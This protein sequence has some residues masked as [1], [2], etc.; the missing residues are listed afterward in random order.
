MDETLDASYEGERLSIDAPPLVESAHIRYREWEVIDTGQLTGEAF[1]QPRDEL[2]DQADVAAPARLVVSASPPEREPLWL[3]AQRVSIVIPALNEAANLPHVLPRI[4]A[5]VQEVILVDGHST[6]NTVA[7]A[8]ELWPNIRVV[9]QEGRG[10]GAA[11]RTGFAAATGDIIVMLDA[12][13]ST[14]PEEIPAFVGML[15]A[16]A[17][18]A[19]GSRFLPGGGTADMSR[20]RRLGNRGFLLLVRAL[21]GYRYSD[22]CYGYNAFWA[23]VLPRL[24]LDRDGFE[25]ETLMNLRARQAGLAVR[26]VPSFEAQ[27]ISGASHLR[28][29]PDGWRVLRTIC[30]ERCGA[31]QWQALAQKWR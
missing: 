18:F 12:D 1:A 13:G 22:L 21:F 28:T 15:L 24:A 25:I 9:L 16:G 26:E 29:I 2:L 30:R 14:V 27:R 17:D 10:K 8:R 3:A 19:K 7:V 6:D 5:W 11:L 4:P 20:F 31:R 23:R